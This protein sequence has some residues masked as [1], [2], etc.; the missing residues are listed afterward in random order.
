MAEP[1]LIKVLNTDTLRREDPIYIYGAG[2][3]GKK[4]YGI[5]ADLGYVPVGFIDSHKRGSIHGRRILDLEAYLAVRRQADQIILASRFE[6]EIAQA[7]HAHGIHDFASAFAMVMCKTDEVQLR[8]MLDTFTT[9]LRPDAGMTPATADVVARVMDIAVRHGVLAPSPN[10]SEITMLHADI[11]AIAQLL[12]LLCGGAVLEV[13]AYVGGLTVPMALAAR[14]ADV[15]IVTL[16]QGGSVPLHPY[17]PSND[18]LADLQAN[19]RRYGV[20][21][22]VHILPGRLQDPAMLRAVQE[23]LGADKIGLFVDD[24]DGDVCGKFA[25]I[26]PLL[27]PGAFIIIDDFL[28]RFR[29]LQ[30]DKARTTRAFVYE[31]V[32]HG[33]FEEIGIFGW[34]TWI[35]RYRVA[36]HGASA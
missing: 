4:V 25:A 21:G 3:S 27:R 11:Q 1:L 5:L 8:A 29:S 28:Q 7:L 36:Q 14:Q 30:A 26:A 23:R 13:G 17:L 24:S 9:F 20:S 2:D 10:Y 32:V 19:L 34:G 35:G 12:V 18:I 31:Q 22:R 6:Q 15:P 16:E 33:T